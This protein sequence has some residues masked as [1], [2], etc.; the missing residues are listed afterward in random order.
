MDESHRAAARQFRHRPSPSAA[1]A[2]A[3]AQFYAISDWVLVLDELPA[4][5][6]DIERHR[7]SF[8]PAMEAR[9]LIPMFVQSDLFGVCMVG[10]AE[11]PL[12]L[13]WEDY[14]VIK[15]ISKQCA[16]FLALEA[17]SRSLIEAQQLSAVNQMSAFLLHDIKTIA[18]QLSLM[19]ENAAKHRDNPAFIDDMLSTTQNS[20]TRME[21]IIAG[22]RQ[23]RTNNASQ[24]MTV[25]LAAWIN[26]RREGNQA[27]KRPLDY[28]LCAESVLVRADPEAL[29]AALTHLEQNALEAIEAEDRVTVKLS[30]EAAWGVLQVID[31]GV[32]MDADFI[33]NE[34]FQPFHS[35]KGL[36]GMGIGAY[37]ARDKIRGCGGDLHVESKVGVGTTFTIKLP[38][39]S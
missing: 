25:D 3:I 20:V 14:D 19:L 12:R 24:I 26:G 31:T 8:D 34:L 18:A 1:L 35:T 30:R 32:G 22:L 39:A 4:A 28:Q 6:A 17:T 15:L 23:P 33:N 10:A 36:T 37:Q 2:E 16:G 5:A 38:L 9:Y 11:I 13:S 29:D 7:S 21:R 27:F